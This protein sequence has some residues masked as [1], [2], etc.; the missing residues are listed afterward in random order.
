MNKRNKI[1]FGLSNAHVWPITATDDNG[2][3]TYG[4]IIN[5]PGSVELALDAE[6]SNDAFYADDVTYAQ[7]AANNG[8]SGSITVADLP[9]DFLTQVL[10]QT[11]DKNGALLE[12]ADTVANEF[13]IAFEF[14][15]DA[16]KRRHLFYRCTATRPS[17]S[18]STKEDSISPNT[19]ELSFSAIPRLDTKIVKASAEEGDA[20]YDMWFGEV[21]YETQIEE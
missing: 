4:A 2:T 11:V 20:A 17:V 3:P 13:A 7:L 21:P 14:K 10:K 1:T 8:Y 19:Q 16:S 15:G 12:N 18:S 6:G 9:R 5:V